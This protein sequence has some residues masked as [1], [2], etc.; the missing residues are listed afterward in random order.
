MGTGYK[1][2]AGMGYEFV[3]LAEF[4]WFKMEPEEGKFEFNWLDKVI[5]LC[6]KYNLK[7]LMCTPSAA[8][9]AWHNP[10]AGG[11]GVYAIHERNKRAQER[12]QTRCYHAGKTGWAQVKATDMLS[13]NGKGEI[14]MG[15]DHYSWNNWADLLVPDKNTETLAVFDNQFYKGKAAVVKHKVG[16]GIVTYIGVDTDDSRLEQDVLRGIY[17][18]AGATTENYPPGVYVYWRDGFYV[19]VN[20]SSD[21]YTMNMPGTANIIVGEKILQPGGV[22]VWNE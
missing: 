13:N 17:T 3:H 18:G 16:K 1:K 9:P 21:N 11:W 19:A 15:P 7:V 14:L 2:I 10:L 12:I 22:L 6:T 5:A 8:T 4:A 20:Y